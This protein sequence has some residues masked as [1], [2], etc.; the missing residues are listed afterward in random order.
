[1][2]H[3]ADT[4]WKLT[5]SS[6]R[7]I[8]WI[9]VGIAI[10]ATFM[11]VYRITYHDSYTD[12]AIL[13]FRSIGLIDYVTAT[14][15]T[16]P[17]QWVKNVPWWMHLSFHD[18]P[19]F[20]FLIQH[21]TIRLFGENL[22]GARAPALFAGVG[23]VIFLFYI[24]R[25]LMGLRGALIASA[26]LS[27]QS[28]HIW[29]SRLGIQD[30]VVIFFLLLTLLLWMLAIERGKWW[31]WTLWGVS[32]GLGVLTKYTSI[33]IVPILVLHALLFRGREESLISRIF[34][35]LAVGQKRSKGTARPVSSLRKNNILFDYGKQ[36]R[37][38]GY[39]RRGFWCGICAIVVITSPIWLYNLLLYRAF[40][41][42][43]FQL[44]ALFGQEVSEWAVRLGRA[45][46][47]DLSDRFF[48]FFRSLFQA[49][50]QWF[51]GVA[52][53][54]FVVASLRSIWK[55]DKTLLFLLGG[56]VVTW[57]WFFVI[58]STYR[59]VVM[60]I[61][62]LVLLVA[63][64]FSLLC[65]KQKRIGLT[66]VAFFFIAE[67]L[68]SINTFYRL[69]P[70]GAE[71]VAYAEIREE[72]EIFGFNEVDQYLNNFFKGRVSALFGQPEYS[73][74]IELV[75]N[76]IQNAKERGAASLSILLIYDD[77][78]PM[79]SKLWTFQRR[80]YYD[81]WPMISDQEFIRLTGDEKD[82]Y[83]RPQGVDTFVYIRPA[84]DIFA[85]YQP[86]FLRQY[87]M[88][89]D[90]SVREE[91]TNY[92]QGKGIVPDVLRNKRGEEVFW[93]YRF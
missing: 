3:T 29:V 36:G 41:H 73:F 11:R 59:F 19:L 15:Q 40:G 9:F 56:A 17:W 44:S 54:A 57:L 74:L 5:M 75:E 32:L 60:I 2:L 34:F 78:L 83:Y 39:R 91:L 30:G 79:L 82:A 81:G 93:V 80:L 47:G 46:T 66:F 49:N 77:E 1:M 48:L 22:M 64:M 23:S 12:E 20:F 35:F 50:S 25:R 16:S 84:G 24:A 92:L 87:T 76:R 62:W 55:K 45:Q 68:F 38:H 37:L 65:I 85:E 18:H 53:I 90:G 58:G 61:P 51:N 7:K 33:I 31:L 4:T 42:F 26:L 89:K 63:W 86:R 72:V 14:Y 10:L 69:R 70:L 27:V 13:A 67:F 28:Y 21:G 8:I 71:R 43:D 6:K 52:I 88:K